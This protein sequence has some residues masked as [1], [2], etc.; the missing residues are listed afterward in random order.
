MS[1]VAESLGGRKS[2]GCRKSGVA[3]SVGGNLSK[4]LIVWLQNVE[5][6]IVELPV[7][8]EPLKTPIP[9]SRLGS[10]QKNGGGS[11]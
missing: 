5:L 3:E 4:W 6:Q 9:F 10:R 11:L 7:V 8:G 2:G 1:G